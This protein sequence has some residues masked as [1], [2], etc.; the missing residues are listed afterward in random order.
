MAQ[1]LVSLLDEQCQQFME[2]V[3]ISLQLFMQVLLGFRFQGVKSKQSIRVS[4]WGYFR[5]VTD[6]TKQGKFFGITV[7]ATVHMM[8]LSLQQV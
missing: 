2:V 5:P 1:N 8:D 3:L 4:Y 7:H 6:L